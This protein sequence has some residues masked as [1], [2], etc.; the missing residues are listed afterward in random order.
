MSRHFGCPIV[1]R[2]R[3][4][5][6][7]SKFEALYTSID[8]SINQIFSRW[9]VYN[10]LFG[11]G[12]ENVDL[13]NRNGSY[14]FFLLQ[15]LLLDDT[16]LSL[17][18]LTDSQRTGKFE[19]ASI[20]HLACLA[21]TE[22]E[23]TQPLSDEIDALLISL[24]KHVANARI[25]RDKAIAHSDFEHSTGLVK[26]PEITYSEIESAMQNLKSLMLK[27]GS[28]AIRRVGNYKPIIAFGT[29]GNKLLSSL[30]ALKP[31]V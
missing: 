14:V 5:R 9:N 19:N 30:R 3:T 4:V 6:A 23:L 20:E 28:K 18:R 21:R 8:Q 2:Y 7:M 1:V 31:C 26:L 17:S 27:M 11:S 24:K 22:L 16:I 10:Q 12:Q 25:H 13:L 29:D 15:R